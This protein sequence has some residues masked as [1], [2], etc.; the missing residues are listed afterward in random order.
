MIATTIERKGA[1]SM[2]AT[3]DEQS[4]VQEQEAVLSSMK[5]LAVI[6]RRMNTD[7]TQPVRAAIYARSKDDPT[8]IVN[9]I[10]KCRAY[11]Q[12]YGYIVEDQHVYQ[13]LDSMSGLASPLDHTQFALLMKAA[14]EHAFNA[15]LITGPDKLS[16][17]FA[18]LLPVFEMFVQYGIA[19]VNVDEITPTFL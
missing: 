3:P 16:R 12:E 14:G 19:V 17:S 7:Q 15:V 13:D 11:A 5:Q 2:T 1:S 6:F 4:F 10:S 9:Q 18:K 8:A